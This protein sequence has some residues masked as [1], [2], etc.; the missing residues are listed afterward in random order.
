M[1]PEMTFATNEGELRALYGPPSD[2]ALRK[3]LSRLDSECQRFIEASPFMCL[4]TAAEDGTADVSPRGDA[5]GF[6][7]VI[8]DQTLFLPDRLGNNRIDSM[9]NILKNPHVGMLF[10]VPGACETLRVSGLARIV[11]HSELLDRYAIDGRVPK[12]GLLIEVREVFLHCTKS[13]VRAKL[14][15]DEYR[16]AQDLVP[17]SSK[18]QVE[19]R[20]LVSSVPN[21]N[22]AIEKAPCEKRY[23]DRMLACV[24]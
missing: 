16:L 8:D 15:S 18:P 22:V 7:T 20:G 9:R 19:Q 4:S 5:P 12:T 3:L 1:L 17:A 2:I 14:W 13:L 21:I 24:K 23:G 6:V 11:V 10:L